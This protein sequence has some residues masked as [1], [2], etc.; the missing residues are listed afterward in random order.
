MITPSSKNQFDFALHELEHDLSSKRGAGSQETED[1]VPIA[2]KL[3]VLMPAP[4]PRLANGRQKFLTEAA[5]MVES[6]S[7]SRPGQRVG[8]AGR[9][10]MFAA[11]LSVLLLGGGTLA[12]AMNGV[13][14][15]GSPTAP[16]AATPAIIPTDTV[17]P[18]RIALFAAPNSAGNGPVPGTNDMFT[19]MPAPSPAPVPRPRA[20]ISIDQLCILEWHLFHV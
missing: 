16:S 15:S 11:I 14:W 6:K 5:R 12:M 18:T 3:A 10:L 13:G 9:R 8:I 2:R 1:L 17:T 4:E 7:G 20:V 19:R